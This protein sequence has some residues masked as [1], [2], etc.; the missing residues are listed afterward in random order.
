MELASTFMQ[1]KEVLI[2]SLGKKNTSAA[3]WNRLRNGLN[4]FN[5]GSLKEHFC[6]IILKS[7]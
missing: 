4:N 2:S 6:E 5:T 7:I 3:E 1:Y